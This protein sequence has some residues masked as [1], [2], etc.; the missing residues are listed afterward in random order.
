MTSNEILKLQLTLDDADE[1]A[2]VMEGARYQTEIVL[3][4]LGELEKFIGE[5]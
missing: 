4:V 2:Y 1:L 5:Q 3:Y